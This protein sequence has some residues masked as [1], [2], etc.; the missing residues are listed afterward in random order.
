MDTSYSLLLKCPL[1]N[2]PLGFNGSHHTYWKKKM[3]DFI[4]AIDTD[5]QDIIELGY[6]VLKVVIDGIF[7]PKVKSLWT[8]KERKKTSSYF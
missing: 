8:K 7:Q 2:K 1:F 4:E 6:E 3:R 5:M